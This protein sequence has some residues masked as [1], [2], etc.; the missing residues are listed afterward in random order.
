MAVQLEVPVGIRGEP[1]VVAAVQHDGVVVGDALGGQ[2]RRELF[3][4]QEVAANTVLQVLAPVQPDG[5]FDMAT[6]VGAG[7]LVDLDEHGLGCIEILLCPIGG[8]QDVGA[9]HGFS[10]R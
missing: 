4:I 8:D 3:L 10:F 7:V 5:A 9:S 6:V 1:V 2:Q